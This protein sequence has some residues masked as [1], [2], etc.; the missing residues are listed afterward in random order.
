MKQSSKNHEL[1]TAALYCRLSR[2]DNL[3]TESNSISNQKK[4]LQKAAGERGYSDTLFFV[5]DGITGTTMKRPG[6]QKMLQAIERGYI[7]AVFVKDLS[8]LGRNYIEV[9]RLTE[10]FFPAHDVRLVAVSDGVDS[11]EGEN[12]F[13]PFKNIM[14]EYYARD[15]SKKRKIVNKLKGNSGVPLSPPPYGY[16]KNPDDPRFWIIDREAAAVVRRI[17]QMALDGYGLAETAA[18]LERDGICNP[19]YYWRSKGT[20][21]GGLKSTVEPTKWG[22]TTIKKILTTQEYCGDIINFKTFSKSYK[23]KKRIE[24]PEENRAVFLNVH[25]AIIDRPTWEKV[26]NLKKGTRRKRP[27]VTQEPSVFSGVLKCPECGGNLNFHFNQGNHDIKFFSCQNHNSGLRKCSRTHY[28]RVEFLEQVVLYEVNR[29]AHFANEYE[30]DFLKAIMG[31]SAKVA[32]NDRARKQR[33]PDVLLA[34]DKELDVLFEKIY[35]DNVNQKIS[36]ARFA[37]MSQRYEQEQGE[38]AKKIKALRLE[39][40]KSEGQRMDVDTFLATVRRYTNATQITRRMVAELIDHINV[41]HAEKK[42]GVTT[43]HITIYYN[44]IG[45]FAVPDRRKIPATQIT[46]GTR[47]GVAVSY[48]PDKTA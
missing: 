32:D 5:E 27:T 10:E 28:I 1:G 46:M 11:D 38:N 17:Y 41:Y 31:Q 48:S 39:L 34:R 40:K 22:H 13:T 16:I 20:N 2:D 35:E 43:Q 47:K 44:C 26:Q 25:E 6:L 21:R 7:A 9:G 42:D 37:K 30:D 3:D 33:E 23:V 18:A 36:D 12:E 29:L 8:R 4:I 15:I 24:T 19:T 14:N 45:A